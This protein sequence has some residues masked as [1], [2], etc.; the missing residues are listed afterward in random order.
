MPGCKIQRGTTITPL[1]LYQL[2][3]V[4]VVRNAATHEKRY[5]HEHNVLYKILVGRESSPPR[6]HER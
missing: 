3:A 4:N 1:S 6:P 2:P 5:S